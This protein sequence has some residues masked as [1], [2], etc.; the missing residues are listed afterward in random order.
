[1]KNL[2][3]VLALTLSSLAFAKNHPS[4]V[5]SVTVFQT[6]AEVI[7]TASLNLTAGEQELVFEGVSTMLDKNNIQVKGTGNLVILGTSYRQNYLNE[8]EL[9]P[10]LQKIKDQISALEM[11]IQEDR[12]MSSSFDMEKQ[13][14]EKNMKI[15]EGQGSVTA[16]QLKELATFYRD[17]I[18]YVGLQRMK[19]DIAVKKKNEELQKLRRHYNDKTAQFRKNSGEIVVNVDVKAATKAN[20]ELIYLVSSAGWKAEYDIRSADVDEPL[21]LSYKAIITQNTGEN[22]QDVKLTLSTG[23]PNASIIKPNLDPQY[24]DFYYQ[25][26]QYKRKMDYGNRLNATDAV[27][28]ASASIME[29]VM[30]MEESLVETLEVASST[31]TMYT[32]YEVERPYSLKSGEKPLNVIIRE[33]SIEADYEYQSAPKLRPRV[34]LI[35]KAKNWGELVL[36]RGPINIFFEGGYV[37]KSYMNPNVTTSNLSISLGY[38]PGI[39]IERK[40]SAD[41]SSKRTIGTNQKETIVYEISIRNNKKKDIKLVIEDQVPV[42][43]NSEIKVENVETNGGQYDLTTGKVKWTVNLASAQKITKQLAYEV[44]YPKDRNI[45][46]L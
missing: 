6:R 21:E 18:N 43:N 31:K 13:L 4:K 3:I 39:N 40:K 8:N 11:K 27:T 26:N 19:L 35:A 46:G 25:S 9:S 1:M 12:I 5:K 34:F 45:S 28:R 44:K 7:R 38:D 32:N 30:E 42:S 24:L 16:A 17:R 29:S 14:L 23:N 2:L 37:G 22:W 36:L 10:E 33:Q 15:N 20:L 41:K